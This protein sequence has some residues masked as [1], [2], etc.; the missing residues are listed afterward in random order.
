MSLVH[1]VSI[2]FYSILFYL[3]AIN[4]YQNNYITISCGVIVGRIGKRNDLYKDLKCTYYSKRP[5]VI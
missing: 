2:S 4:Q 3:A 1:C 5:S